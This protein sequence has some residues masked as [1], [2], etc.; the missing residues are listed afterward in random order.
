MRAAGDSDWWPCSPSNSPDLKSS[1][2]FQWENTT[3]V[4]LGRYPEI[5]ISTARQ[6]SQASLPERGGGG[7][8]GIGNVNKRHGLE[9]H[10]FFRTPGWLIEIGIGMYLAVSAGFC[11]SAPLDL[12]PLPP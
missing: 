10:P 5:D 9:R 6:A 12:E 11:E 4:P 1:T 3:Q 2:K 8:G 7:E